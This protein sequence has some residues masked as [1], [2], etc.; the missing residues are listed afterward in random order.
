MGSSLALG[1]KPFLD[2]W[3]S[4]SP[5]AVSGGSFSNFAIRR[6][7]SVVLVVSVISIARICRFKSGARAVAILG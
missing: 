7:R 4:L 2:A 5:S 6:S 3:G 1:I